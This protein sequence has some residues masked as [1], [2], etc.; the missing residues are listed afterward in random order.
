M[1]FANADGS[2][3][4]VILVGNGGKATSEDYV[5]NLRK[6]YDGSTEAKDNGDGFYTFSYNDDDVVCRVLAG[7]K[8]G[9]MMALI[10]MGDDPDL[11]TLAAS[12]RVK[13]QFRP[14]IHALF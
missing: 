10:V 12:V 4:A 8:E 7:V 1:V 13:I 3:A 9:T 11:I 2:A 14:N 5:E 6:Q